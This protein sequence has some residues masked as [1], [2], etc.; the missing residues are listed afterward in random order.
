MTEW[1]PCG[2]L[3]L[4]PSSLVM[5]GTF[6]FIP[7]SKEIDDYKP[8]RIKERVDNNYRWVFWIQDWMPK[9]SIAL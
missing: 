8:F 4:R 6:F 3:D 7:E 9:E 2:S 1:G 5:T